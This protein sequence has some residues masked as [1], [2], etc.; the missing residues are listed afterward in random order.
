M[1]D[2]A[3]IWARPWEGLP[4]P[5][6]RLEFAEG[7]IASVQDTQPSGDLVA[8]PGLINA[9]D[10]GRGLSPPSY[11]ASDAP[12]EAWLWD[13]WRAP[14]VDVYLSHAVAFGRMLLSGVTTVVHNHL[15][16]GSDFLAEAREVVRAARDTGLRLAMVVPIIDR[17]IA[18]YDG[19]AAVTA[20]LS[21]SERAW[22]KAAQEMPPLSE[23]IA[24]VAEIADAIDGPF[25]TTQYGPPG[26]QWLSR[27]GWAL[28]GEAAASDGRRIHTHLLETLPQRLWLDNEEPCGAGAFFKGAGLLN[29][30]LTV[31]HGVWLDQAELSVLAEAKTLLALNT[32]SN[33]RLGSGQVDGAKL[34]ATDVR[35]GIGLDGLALDDDADIWREL[36]LANTILGPRGIDGVGLERSALLRAVFST[37]RLAYD[38]HEGEGLT[39]GSSADVVCLSLSAIASDQIDPRAEVTAALI[40]GRASRAAVRSVHV[41]GRETVRDGQLTGLDLAAASAEL[42]AQARARFRDAPPADWYAKAR[43]ATIRANG[44]AP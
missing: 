15:P 37:G 41:A 38:G 32:S 1:I 17:N 20:A 12:L 5:G 19:G 34:L 21:P 25:V 10:H 14:E 36:R 2:A 22:L 33:L 42:T 23:Q 16:Q 35:L 11:G 43:A 4:T 24:R 30:R 27:D 40:V 44:G 28:V 7:R 3:A 13:L 29:D 9:H 18:G 31:A 26:P 6:G 8:V 39:V